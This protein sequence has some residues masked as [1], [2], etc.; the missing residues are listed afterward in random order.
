[1]KIVITTHSFVPFSYGGREKMVC[2][3]SKLLS[4]ENK[5]KILTSSDSLLIYEKKKFKNLTI[6]YL[7][8][9]VIALTNAS[10]RVPIFLFF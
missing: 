1:M 8:T 7:P 3:F 5:V 4:K 9:L 6:E 2:Y 10:Y